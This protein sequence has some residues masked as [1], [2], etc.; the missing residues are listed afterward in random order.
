[1][2]AEGA[3]L[4]IAVIVAGLL[5]IKIDERL[6]RRR[7]LALGLTDEEASQCQKFGVTFE[8]MAEKKKAAAVTL[9]NLYAAL[10]C[11]P[12][13]PTIKPAPDSNTDD[14]PSDPLVIDG[15]P[16]HGRCDSG[17]SGGD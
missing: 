6:T 2:G 7:Q 11:L 4:M 3:L 14:N 8:E 15:G 12:R 1:M 9:R 16:D 13:Q 17:S 10:A 5:I